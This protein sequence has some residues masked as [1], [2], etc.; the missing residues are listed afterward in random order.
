MIVY[1]ENLKEFANKF[2]QLTRKYNKVAVYKVN[3]PR[4]F[5]VFQQWTIRIELKEKA[6]PLSVAQKYEVLK[7]KCI[8]ICMKS[9]SIKV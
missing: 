6:V 5:L 4:Q 2:L 7:H 8:K 1:A 9:I 3:N